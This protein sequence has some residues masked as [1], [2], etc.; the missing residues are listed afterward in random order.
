LPAQVFIAQVP[1]APP[2]APASSGRSRVGS[3]MAP[4]D[5]V[6]IAD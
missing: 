2:T 4:S 5:E 3:H 1:E 6:G